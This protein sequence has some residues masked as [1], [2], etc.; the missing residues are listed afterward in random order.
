MTVRLVAGAD[1]HLDAA[2]T[3]QLFV[4][5]GAGLDP[6]RR[7]AGPTHG[8]DVT[9][10]E[11]LVGPVPPAGLAG[12][13][14]PGRPSLQSDPKCASAAQGKMLWARPP[15]PNT[16]VATSKVRHTAIVIAVRSLMAPS[17]RPMWR[18]SR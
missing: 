12:P 6:V 18:R 2:S 9:I 17:P 4:A 8:A 16:N 13:A 14:R 15:A 11:V 5:E 10:A 1:Q 3:P 7:H